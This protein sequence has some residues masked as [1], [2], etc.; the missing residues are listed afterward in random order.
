MLQLVDPTNRLASRVSLCLRV[1]VL[2]SYLQ[3]DLV[4]QVGLG[5]LVARVDLCLCGE[6]QSSIK[7]RW[8]VSGQSSSAS[9][10]QWSAMLAD[11]SEEKR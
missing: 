8:L 1:P 2:V 10:C 4:G 9:Y 6:R 11:A 7:I 3:L 5:G